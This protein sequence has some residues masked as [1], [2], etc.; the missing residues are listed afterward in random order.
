M[1]ATIIVGFYM[2]V[3]LLMVAFDLVFLLWEKVR[4]KRFAKRAERM[5]LA[6]GN[7]VARNLDFPTEE[8]RKM[9]ERRLLRLPGMESFDVTMGRMRQTAP[10]E[11]D[12]Y[13]RGIASVFDRLAPRYAERRD[14]DRAY[15]ADMVR[16][17]YRSDELSAPMHAMLLAGAE[18][19]SFYVRQ[20]ALEALAQVGSACDLAAAVG[21]VDQSAAPHHRRLVTETLLSFHGNAEEL[22]DQLIARMER[23]SPEAQTAVVNY[24]RM[25]KAARWGHAI[26]LA[27]I[28]ASARHLAVPLSEDAAGADAPEEPAAETHLAAGGG[29][30]PGASVDRYAL[31]AAILS[32]PSANREVRLACVR[33]FGANRYDGAYD[34]LCAMASCTA[35]ERWEYAAVAASALA[36]YP[37]ARTVDIL[38][39]CLSS[40]AYHVRFNAAKSLHELGLSLEDDLRH[41]AEGPDRYAREMLR[42]RWNMQGGAQ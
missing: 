15:F 27:G 7:E 20:N 39:T 4:N 36:A 12:R 17:W 34:E 42:Y 9:L 23:F 24:L 37:E 41:I 21:S 1:S 5:A 3:S 13:L 26:P 29:A 11:S 32:D 25:S 35:P 33:F 2:G 22:A 40:S 14:L 6:L 31:L 16:K 30:A 18:G 19:G 10:A 28:H 8:H 38:A